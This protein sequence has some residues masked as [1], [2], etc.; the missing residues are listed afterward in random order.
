MGIDT[1][2]FDITLSSAPEN[3]AAIE[4]LVEKVKEEFGISDEIF[5]NMMVAVT[6]AVNNA[7]IHG[8]KCDPNKKVTITV[9]R[10]DHA[11]HFVIKDEG[12]GFD[13]SNLPDPTA[14]ENIEKISGRGVFLMNQ[15][16]DVVIFGNNGSVIELQF[17][18]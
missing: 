10:S 15:L 4:P 1:A 14:P 3:I 13:Y 12:N 7:I 2:E 11:V 16:S 6:E 9:S 17:R 5:G 18:I 8:N